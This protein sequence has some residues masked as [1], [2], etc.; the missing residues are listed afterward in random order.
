L[1]ENAVDAINKKGR[2]TERHLW[3]KTARISR[4]WIEITIQDNGIG[5]RTEHLTDIFD[6]EWSTKETGLGFGLYWTKDYIEGIGGSIN[7]DSVWGMG[8]TFKISLPITK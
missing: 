8:T 6:L 5:I 3:I 7:V 2:Q 1:V 4:D